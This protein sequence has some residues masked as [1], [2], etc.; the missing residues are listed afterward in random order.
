MKH[1]L[2]SLSAEIKI[3][4]QFRFSFV[5]VL[6]QFSNQIKF[7]S[8]RTIRINMLMSLNNPKL[9]PFVLFHFLFT[10]ADVGNKAEIKFCCFGFEVR[11]S[12]Q[13]CAQLLVK[14][15]RSR[16]K[17]VSRNCNKC[18]DLNEAIVKLIFWGK[19]NP[20]TNIQ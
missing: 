18:N 14:C 11:I 17:N 9:F 1:K 13:L 6:Y 12:F 16:L 7:I 5:S 10:C 8:I 19:R 15:V 2:S 20:S 3:L 4:F